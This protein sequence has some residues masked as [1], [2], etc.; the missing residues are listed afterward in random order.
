MLTERRHRV[1]LTT[2]TLSELS[3]G[4]SERITRHSYKVL[5]GVTRS[6]SRFSEVTTETFSPHFG[7][8]PP[9]PP[10]YMNNALT[11]PSSWIDWIA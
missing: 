2:W 3:L 11:L 6:R 5:I 4:G 1:D 8:V 7:H 9:N 10:N